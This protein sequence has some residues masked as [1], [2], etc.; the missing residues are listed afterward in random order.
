LDAAWANFGT[1]TASLSLPRFFTSAYMAWNGPSR[2]V[3][4]RVIDLDEYK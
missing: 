2:I 1:V 3:A 4:H